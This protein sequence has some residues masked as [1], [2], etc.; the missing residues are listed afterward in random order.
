MVEASTGKKTTVK[1][2]ETKKTETKP[3]ID[4][5]NTLIMEKLNQ[6]ESSH[7]PSPSEEAQKQSKA[8]QSEL[9]VKLDAIFLN[10]D[11]DNKTKVEELNKFYLEVVHEQLKNEHKKNIQLKLEEEVNDL[12]IS[13]YEQQKQKAT[14]IL[15]KQQV[16]TTEYQNQ[17]KQFQERHAL[18]IQAE[19]QKRMEI[20]TNFDNHLKQIKQQMVEDQERMKTENEIQKENDQLKK[21]YEELMKE[22]EEKTELMRKQIEEKDSQ[23]GTIEVEMNKKISSQEEEIKKQVEIYREQTKIKIEEEKELIKVFND[24]KKKHD[25]FSKAMKKSKETFKVYENEIKNMNVKIQELL[26]QRKELDK[27]RKGA[28]SGKHD[29]DKLVSDWTV[30]REALN[31]ERDNLKQMCSEIQESIKAR[32]QGKSAK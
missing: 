7:K 2:L 4:D 19:T 23:A 3:T 10:T 15:N 26:K 8:E 9:L 20:I 17:F 1:L 6:L 13:V 27:S 32:T 11:F 30:E 18:I 16:L 14:L 29:Y 31:K 24:Y 28:K 12:K 21:Q 25:E 22:I 5:L